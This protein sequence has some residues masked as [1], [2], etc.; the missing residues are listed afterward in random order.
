MQCKMRLQ[1][2]LAPGAMLQDRDNTTMQEMMYSEWLGERE[3]AGTAPTCDRTRG[4]AYKQVHDTLPEP[5]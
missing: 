1:L 2:V 5:R 3:A 4:D